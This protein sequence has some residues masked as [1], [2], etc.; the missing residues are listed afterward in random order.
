M[1][2]TITDLEDL[3]LDMLRDIYYAEKKIL[4][5]LPKMARAVRKETPELA[6]AFEKHCDETGGQVDR[7]ER[8]FEIFGKRATGKKC[9]AIEGILEEGEEL[10]QSVDCKCTLSA[11]LLAGAQAV[12]HYEMARYGT[13]VEWAR[14]LDQDEAADLL[15]E[16]L[17]QEKDTDSALNELA[18]DHVN[19]AAVETMTEEGS[20]NDQDDDNSSSEASYSRPRRRA[21]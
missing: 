9:A 10:I 6:E 14:L 1:P 11:G 20:E 13:L 7:L 12:E 17:D 16:T 3:F 2:A 15:Q 18:L 4:R 21:A 19:Q 5:A 8:V